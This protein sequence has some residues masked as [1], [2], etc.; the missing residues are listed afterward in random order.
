MNLPASQ[1]GGQLEQQV[2]PA[3]NFGQFENNPG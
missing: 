3:L 1:P 2:S